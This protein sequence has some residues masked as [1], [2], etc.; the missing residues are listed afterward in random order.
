[1]FQNITEKFKELFKNFKKNVLFACYICQKPIKN[2][3]L[4]VDL[5]SIASLKVLKLEYFTAFPITSML[6]IF[7]VTFRDI[8]A[9]FS[10]HALLL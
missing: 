8:L 1:M 7:Q 9:K 5:K 6:K 10:K 4:E 3:A 2:C